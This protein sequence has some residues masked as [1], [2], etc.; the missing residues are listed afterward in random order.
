MKEYNE[1][2]KYKKGLI[3]K[4]IKEV[5]FTPDTDEGL[6]VVMD[7]GWVLYFGFSGCEGHFSVSPK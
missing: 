2:E 4:T 1:I 6:V 3:G 7:D 5:H